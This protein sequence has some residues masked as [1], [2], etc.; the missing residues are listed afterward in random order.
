[1]CS[2]DEGAEWASWGWL[3]HGGPLTWLVVF[4]ALTAVVGLILASTAL[5]RAGIGFVARHL[6]SRRVST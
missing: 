6:R 2:T 3:L 1:M 4:L 5:V